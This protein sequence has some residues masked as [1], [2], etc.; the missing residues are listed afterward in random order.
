MKFALVSI[1]CII[2]PVILYGVDANTTQLPQTTPLKTEQRAFGEPNTADMMT[3]EEAITQ[4]KNVRRFSP[5]IIDGS[6]LRQLAWAGQNT[7]A[8]K[9][10]NSIELY[11]CL[12]DGVYRCNQAANTLESQVSGDVRSTLT[13]AAQNEAALQEAPCAI[14]I[15]GTI[16]PTATNI[17]MLAHDKMMLEAGKRSQNIELEAISLGLG[18]LGVDFFDAARI[19]RIIKLS[20]QQ[21]PLYLLALGYPVGTTPAPVHRKLQRHALLIIPGYRPNELF[22][23]M[24]V[25]MAANIRITIAQSG[26]TKR[27]ME[28]YQRIIEPDMQIQDVVTQNYDAVIVIGGAGNLPFMR[29]PV[30]LNIIRAAVREGKIVGAI[31]ETTKVL[32][33]AGVVNGVRVTGDRLQLLRSGCIYTEQLVESDQGIVTAL[34]EQQASWFARMIIDAM[35]NQTVTPRPTPIPLPT[36]TTTTRQPPYRTF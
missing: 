18:T 21:E 31:G 14:V 3:V 29:E 4:Q 20:P 32:A 17:R 15:A 7:V 28:K 22:N 25:L 36:T 1:V 24:D 16:S 27:S 6:L 35:S 33:N 11:F 19:K 26:Q 34:T 5:Q 2:F 23:I 10:D 13:I 30:I 12:P 9:N 8:A